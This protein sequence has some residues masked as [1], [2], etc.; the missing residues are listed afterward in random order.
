[1]QLR[2]ECARLAVMLAVV[3]L[4]LTACGSKPSGPSADFD[5]T[6]FK[7]MAQRAE[8]ADLANRLYLI[9]GQRVFW[10]IEGNCADASYSRTL[11]GNTAE[12]VLCQVHDSI[13]GPVDECQDETDRE[14]FET[15]VANLD[16][17]DLGLG[18]DHRVEEIPF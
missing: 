7:Q 15:I 1:M 13:A 11:F 6:P 8:C 10:N 9:D 14:M 16:K 17:P 5:L 4:L 12:A 18:S 3:P 2:R